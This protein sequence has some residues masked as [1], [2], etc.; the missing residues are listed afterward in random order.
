MQNR[1]ELHLHMV[2]SLP[3]KTF[4]MLTSRNYDELTYDEK[5]LLDKGELYRSTFASD[6]K[7][8]AGYLKKT[9]LP[10]RLLQKPEDIAMAFEDLVIELDN[11]DV[12]YA[13]IRFSPQQHSKNVKSY[14]ELAHEYE[15]IEAAINGINRGMRGRRIVVNLIICCMRN[16]SQGIDGCVANERV[17]FLMAEFLNKGVCGI[18]LAGAELNHET[19]DFKYIFQRAKEMNIPFTIHAGAIT[20]EECARRNLESAIEFGA[21][22]ISNG[23]GLVH[24]PELQRMVRE[25]GITLECCLKSTLDTK[26]VSSINDHPIR[27]FFDSGM[28]VTLNTDNM[29]VSNTNLD[30]EYSLARSIGFTDED[31]NKMKKYAFEGAFM[32][33]EQRK[34]ISSYRKF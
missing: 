13:E 15:L 28:H 24:F 27:Y 26:V 31:I 10:C 11:Q 29:T 21:K 17:L 19:A 18:D 5:K 33:A 9:N 30:R 6:C 1:V 14:N 32:T 16:L 25:R 12:L 3:E 8:L 22:R 7:D 4:N 23:V 2:G 20:D 34:L